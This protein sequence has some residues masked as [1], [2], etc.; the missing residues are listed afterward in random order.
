MN[1]PRCNAVLAE[2][3]VDGIELEAC[4]ACKGAWFDNDELRQ[5]KDLSNPDAQW[6]DFDIWQQE[7]RLTA[8]PNDI[9]CP[10]C[11][12]VLCSLAYDDT[13][14]KI[15]V[16]AAC[17]GVWLDAD[18]LVHIVSALDQ[19]INTKPYGRYVVE[20]IKEAAEILTGPESLASE[21]RDF[22]EVLRLL[23]LRLFVQHPNVHKT[24]ET[25][26]KGIPIR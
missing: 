4:P 7:D 24:V 18:E 22:K 2:I 11:E 12:R 25:I 15:D 16:C 26:Q 23:N 17:R 9:K 14:V 13:D 5:A 8:S 3:I 19:E 21:W 6:M 20:A 10:R 1:C